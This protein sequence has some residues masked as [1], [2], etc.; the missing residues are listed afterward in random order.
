LINY[1]YVRIFANR[2]LSYIFVILYT[3]E[4]REQALRHSGNQKEIKVPNPAR[5]W[6]I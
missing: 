1:I 5:Y 4:D 3:D 6:E 2:S